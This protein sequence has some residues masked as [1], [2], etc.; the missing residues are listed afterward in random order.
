MRFLGTKQTWPAIAL[1]A[2]SAGLLA[3]P[4]HRSSSPAEAL[5]VQPQAIDAVTSVIVR[6][7]DA[8]PLDAV[9]QH[10]T[11]H[12]LRVAARVER[13]HA[14][15]VAVAADGLPRTIATMARAPGV[16]YV[17]PVYS[18]FRTADT[19]ADP[20]YARTRSYLSAVHAPEAWDIEKG[21]PEVIVAVLDTGIDLDHPD[22]QGRIW[23]NAAEIAGNSVDDDANGCIDD[24]HGCAFVDF[25][26]GGCDDAL[27]GD[28][29]DDIGH[30]TFVAGIIAANGNDIGIVGVARNVTVLPIKMLDCG[31]RGQSKGLADGILYA[32]EAGAHVINVSLGGPFDAQI[33]REAV[34]TATQEHGAIIVAAT[35]NTGKAGV[36]YPAR[37]SEVLAVGAASSRDPD[38]RA[39]FSTY[40]PE[41]DVV[42]VGQKIV[43]TVPEDSCT[44]FLPCI[45]DGYAMGDGTSFSAPQVSG[46]A[47][48]I[49]S[50]RPGITPESLTDVI[51]S[52][53]D[54]VPSGDKPNWAGAG[55]INM[56]EALRPQFRLS[57]P[58]TAK[59]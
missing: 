17:E 15:E 43:G 59:N 53:A 36:A 12:G 28:V 47:A 22:L 11:A 50:R 58:G 51:K 13:L 37:Y 10:A 14:V 2:L 16:A 25:A 6:V 7:D 31:G 32:A 20:L 45:G 41:V 52:T 56:F 29:D 24:V 39:K 48:L 21:R 38:A 34:R 57:A 55:R 49:V 46:L 23:T 44:L 4:S 40:G 26:S 18:G 35:G 33:V 54:A 5:A 3:V 27:N 30:G 8:A 42:A 9:A 1:F 19:P